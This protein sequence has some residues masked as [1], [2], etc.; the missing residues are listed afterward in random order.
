MGQWFPV[1]IGIKG[2]REMTDEQL[3][4]L[5]AL[6]FCRAIGDMVIEQNRPKG[7]L[8]TLLKK[9]ITQTDEELAVLPKP[10]ANDHPK[11]KK[12]FDEFGKQTGLYDGKKADTVEMVSFTLVLIEEYFKK[13]CVRVIKTLNDLIEFTGFRE[14]DNKLYENGIKMSEIWRKI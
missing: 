3:D 7:K 8:N 1:R 5:S 12:R 11:I 14:G 9:L 4:K 2:D 13:G 10:F 6:A